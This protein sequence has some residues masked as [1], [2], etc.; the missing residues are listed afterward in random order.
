[1]KQTEHTAPTT[2]AEAQELKDLENSWRHPR[3]IFGWLSYTTHQAIGMRYIVTAFLFL[4]AGGIE[5]ALMRIQ[6]ARADNNFLGPDRY[7][8]IFT[9]HGTTMMFL[10]AVPMMEGMAIWLVP[11]MLG[12]RNVA[13]PRLNAFGYWSYLFGALF[14]YWGVFTNAAPDMGWF[15]YPPLAGPQFG[16]GKRVDIWAQMITF[17]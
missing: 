7:N 17:T 12:T 8:E 6:L 15:G 9:T 3:G 14:L 5:A 16:P 10:F 11:M 2:E 4:L 1:M 13:F